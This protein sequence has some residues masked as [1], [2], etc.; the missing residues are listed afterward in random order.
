[1]IELTASPRLKSSL[2]MLVALQGK[3]MWQGDGKKRNKVKAKM[4]K[5]SRK[6]NR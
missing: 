3:P 5:A 4:A 6:R 1:M 2:Q